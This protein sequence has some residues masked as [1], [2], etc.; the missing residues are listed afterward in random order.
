V[1]REFSKKVESYRRDFPLSLMG[2][3]MKKEKN[4]AAVALGRLGG[5]A[6]VRK[7]FAKFTPERLA[8]ISRKGNEAKR[9]KREKESA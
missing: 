8:E 4:P 3:E 7:G 1:A 2:R 5:K 6:H 9:A